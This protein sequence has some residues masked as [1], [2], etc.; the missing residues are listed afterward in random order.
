M[1]SYIDEG[2]KKIEKKYAQ[3]FRSR[4]TRIEQYILIGKKSEKFAPIELEVIVNSELPEEI[5]AEIQALYQPILDI[6]S[7]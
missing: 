7:N 4:N 6:S 3:F 5:K 1:T 2:Y